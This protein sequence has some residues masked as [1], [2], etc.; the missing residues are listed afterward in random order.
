MP[1]NSSIAACAIACGLSSFAD[2][3][4]DR[5]RLAAAGADLLGD[6]FGARRR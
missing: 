3:E 4:R 6:P 2:V 5:D 1:P